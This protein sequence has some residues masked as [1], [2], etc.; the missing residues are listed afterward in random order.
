LED[1]KEKLP[2][3][4]KKDLKDLGCDG[5]KLIDKSSIEPLS[6]VAFC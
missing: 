3:E 2:N 4:T 5:N 6:S 1:Q